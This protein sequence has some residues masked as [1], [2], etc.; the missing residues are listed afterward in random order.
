MRST[1]CLV[2]SSRSRIAV[3]GRVNGAMTSGR[4]ARARLTSVERSV[5]FSGYGITSTTSKPG[6][7]ALCAARKFSLCVLPKRSF[8]YMTTT[9]FGATLASRK[10]SV[11]YFTALRPKVTALGKFR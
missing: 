6:F 4:A 10:I 1:R 11:M 2:I 9:R 3:T 5:A 7:A 8:E